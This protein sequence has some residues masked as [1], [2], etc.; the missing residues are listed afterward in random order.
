MIQY[1]VFS[2][3][4]KGYFFKSDLIAPEG[5]YEMLKKYEQRLEKIIS[6]CMP[7]HICRITYTEYMD[8][9]TP[10]LHWSLIPRIDKV[11]GIEILNAQTA[12][13]FLTDSKTHEIYLVRE[14]K[15]AINYLTM[16]FSEEIKNYSEKKIFKENLE[17]Q[18]M[19]S[20]NKKDNR[21]KK[22]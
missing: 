3:T 11:S 12:K 7:E 5:E 22:I 13:Q 21:H 19:D 6:M 20:G 9:E 14:L 8:D 15:K 17:T 10:D 16:H 1:Q 2:L 4:Q 18:L